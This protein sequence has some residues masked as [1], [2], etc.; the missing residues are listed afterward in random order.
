MRRI[1]RDRAL[2]FGGNKGGTINPNLFLPNAGPFATNPVTPFAG[3]PDLAVNAFEI[4]CYEF[5]K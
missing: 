1:G 3:L 2:L 5:S 4:F